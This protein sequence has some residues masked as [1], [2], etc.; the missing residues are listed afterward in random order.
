MRPPLFIFCIMDK[1]DDT[2]PTFTH[3]IIDQRGL[4]RDVMATGELPNMDMQ[5]M[6]CALKVPD[7]IVFTEIVPDI[8]VDFGDPRDVEKLGRRS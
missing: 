2:G 7:E 6:A 5:Q 4:W 8:P 1:R 3:R